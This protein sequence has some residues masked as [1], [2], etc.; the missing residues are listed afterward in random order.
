MKR[1]YRL[2]RGLGFVR[3][4]PLLWEDEL[5]AFTVRHVFRLRERMGNTSQPSTSMD[6]L[7]VSLSYSGFH[8]FPLF[9]ID[10]QEALRTVPSNVAAIHLDTIYGMPDGKPSDRNTLQL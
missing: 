3:R 6:N 8:R 2:F 10:T 4:L 1:Y 9:C 5:G 7:N